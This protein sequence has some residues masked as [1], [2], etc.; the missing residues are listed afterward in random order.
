MNLERPII[1]LGS[2]R[3]GTSLT[4][5]VLAACGAWVGEC[6]PANRF[7]PKGYFENVRLTQHR[8]AG[9]LT[10]TNVE[11]VLQ[12]EGYRGGQWLYKCAPGGFLH[13]I[14]FK[15]LWVLVY[16]D[17]EE[18]VASRLRFGGLS[19]LPANYHDED[20]AR[21]KVRDDQALMDRIYAKPPGDTTAIQLHGAAVLKDECTRK[22]LVDACGLTYDPDAVGAFLDPELW[23][24][25]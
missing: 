18:V 7:N 14:R 9:S 6:R 17:P 20:L 4:A 15:P 12:E 8:K 2:P 13:W 23:H 25:E 19:D 16:R 1:V 21:Q 3:S 10:P 5:G 24:G 11:R 22:L